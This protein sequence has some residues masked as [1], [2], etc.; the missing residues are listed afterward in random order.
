VW[1]FLAGQRNYSFYSECED[2][3]GDADLVQNFQTMSYLI[4]NSIHIWFPVGALQAP[5]ASTS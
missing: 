1:V 3:E 5:P 4:I 2:S